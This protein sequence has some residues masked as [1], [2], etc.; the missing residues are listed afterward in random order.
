LKSIINITQIHVL[1]D[2]WG[3]PRDKEVRQMADSRRKN[4]PRSSMTY[5]KHTY[6]HHLGNKTA[7]ITVSRDKWQ[8]LVT[9][10]RLFGWTSNRTNSI[11]TP[12]NAFTT[13]TLSLRIKF[14]VNIT[15]AYGVS[16]VTNIGLHHQYSLLLRL[17]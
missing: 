3:K 15:T 9:L 16:I 13:L 5:Q 10:F 8:A 4:F 2:F 6:F 11:R 17:L 7:V 14:N 1:G 12:E